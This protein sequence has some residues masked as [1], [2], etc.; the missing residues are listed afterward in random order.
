MR[1]RLPRIWL[2]TDERMG[3]RLWDALQR[4]PRGSGVVFR[5]YG[6]APEA[7]KR[8]FAEIA[9]VAAA[10]RLVLVRAGAARIGR[11]DGTH[12]RL[13]SSE[14][15]LKTAPAHSRIEAI[16]AIR[17]GADLLF[18]SPVFATRS[19]PGACA[20]GRVRFGLMIHGLSIP[21]IAL[22]GMDA[23]RFAGLR[24]IGVRGWAG[25]DAWL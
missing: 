9:R 16:R 7:R 3:E 12:G 20:L 22:G 24:Q 15:G 4:L 21:V 13:R 23:K 17:G 6:L 10:R 18:V 19:H 1:R 14:P 8:L 11:A 25:I 2:M 5:H